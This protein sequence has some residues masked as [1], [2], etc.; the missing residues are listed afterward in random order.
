MFAMTRTAALYG[1]EGIPVSVE[2]ESAR[3][4]PALNIIGLGDTAV[5]EAAERVRSAIVNSGFNYPSGRLTANLSPAWVRKKGTHY[6]LALAACVL[7]SENIIRHCS[8]EDKV[9]IGELSLN[10]RIMPVKGILPM[11]SGICGSLAGTPEIYVP[12]D[13]CAEAA[14][15]VDGDVKVIAVDDLRQLVEVLNG[16]REKEYAQAP[17]ITELDDELDQIPDFADV[18]GHFAAKEAIVIAAAGGHGLLLIG[19]PGTGKSMLAKRIP[20][21]LPSMS[22]KEQLE[23]SMVYSLIGK[24]DENQPIIT[25]RPFRQ[26]NKRATPVTILGGGHQPLPGEVSLAHNGILFMD[27]FLEFSR[28]QIELLRV[29]IEEGSV[30]IV[31][32]SHAYVFPARFTLAA[33]TNPCKCG[34]L[35]DKEKVCTCTQ[36]EIDRYRSRLSGPIAERIDLCIEI[37]RVDYKSLTGDV[38]ATGASTLEMRKKVE[39][40]REIQRKR[41]AG[42]SITLNSQMEEGDLKKFCRLGEEEAEFMKKVYESQHLSPRRYHKILKIARTIADVRGSENIEM[43]HLAV[44]LGYT[45]FLNANDRV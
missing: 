16:K 27:E 7:V 22:K 9:F 29:P 18:K 36:T 17:A 41:F 35:G 6:D 1:I 28:E 26:V 13:N 45:S 8:L 3:G 11:L 12:R 32:R 43:P 25:R 33:A 5:K 38:P 10:G 2:L 39:E 34:Y 30:A 23:T 4:L 44:A 21:I 40:A 42:T 20:G 24:L 14:L 15:S 19:S 31:R 37:T